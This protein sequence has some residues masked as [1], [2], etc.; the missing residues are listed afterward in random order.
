MAECIQGKN[1]ISASNETRCVFVDSAY[2]SAQ[3]VEKTI[4]IVAKLTNSTSPTALLTPGTTVFPKLTCDGENAR[5]RSRELLRQV[6]LNR[7][8]KHMRWYIELCQ[9]AAGHAQAGFYGVVCHEG[10][11]SR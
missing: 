8:A 9:D 3:I 5:I 4:H 7:E 2:P 6:R 10:Q 1:S 11:L